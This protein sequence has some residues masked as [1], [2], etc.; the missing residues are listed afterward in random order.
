MRNLLEM[1]EINPVEM[2]LKSGVENEADD[3]RAETNCGGDGWSL[4][5]SKEERERNNAD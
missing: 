2:K 4:S 3:E 5:Q 1:S